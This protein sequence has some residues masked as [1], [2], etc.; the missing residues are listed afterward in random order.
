MRKLLLILIALPCLSFATSLD[1]TT[2]KCRDM[3]ITSAT[4]LKKVQS[5]CLI[6]EQTSNNG[7]FEV[8]FRNDATG[9]IVECFFGSNMPNSTVNGCK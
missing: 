3:H 6:D 2:L 9:K 4:T 1:M 7:L 8:D 5:T